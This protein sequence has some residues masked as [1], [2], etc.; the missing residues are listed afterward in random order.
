[1]CCEPGQRRAST[2][3]PPILLTH[4]VKSG[5]GAVLSKRLRFVRVEPGGTLRFAGWVPSARIQLKQIAV[6]D[7]GSLRGLSQFPRLAR[8]AG[9][10]LNLNGICSSARGAHRRVR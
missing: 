9:V 6:S 1:M 2:R 10:E 8:V 5:D 7:R 3:R 4:E